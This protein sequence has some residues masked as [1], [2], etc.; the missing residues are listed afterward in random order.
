MYVEA[1]NARFWVETAGEGDPVVFIHF[2]LGDD[3]RAHQE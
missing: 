3:Q 2:G 1:N